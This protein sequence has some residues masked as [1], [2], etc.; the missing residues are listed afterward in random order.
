[1]LHLTSDTFDST[2]S[3]STIPILVD[4]W[5]PWCAPC[6]ALNPQLERIEKEHPGTLLLAKVNAD[7]ESALCQRLGVTGLPTLIMFVGGK[8]VARKVGAAGGYMAVKQLVTPHL[9]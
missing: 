9:G 2:V 4:V 1:M 5:A 3:N 7:E 6:K 8:E